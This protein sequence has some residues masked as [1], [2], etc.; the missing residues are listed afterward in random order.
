MTTSG[1]QSVMVP[2][3]TLMPKLSAGNLDTCHLVSNLE[4]HFCWNVY[5]FYHHT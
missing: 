1:G 2:G 4:R 5:F 3:P